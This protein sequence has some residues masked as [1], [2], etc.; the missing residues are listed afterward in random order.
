MPEEIKPKY[1]EEEILEWAEKNLPHL[2][3]MNDERCRVAGIN[4]PQDKPLPYTLE[5]I[6]TWYMGTK[7]KIKTYIKEI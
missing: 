6:R 7:E 5:L 3:K 1:S 2:K 4:S